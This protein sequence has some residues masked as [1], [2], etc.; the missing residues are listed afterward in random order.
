[1]PIFMYS[2]RTRKGEKIDGMVDAPD[3]R[4]ALAQIER[5]G[6]IPVS[7]VEKNAAAAMASSSGPRRRFSF[8]RRVEKLVSRELLLFTTELSDLL[9]SGMKL[10][11]ALN[12]I[13]G[14]KSGTAADRIVA[15]LRDDIIQ[16]ASLS[17]AMAKHPASFPSLYI[18]MIRAGEA[19]G[20]LDEVLGRL[21]LHY[22]KV[23]ETKEKVVM[24]LIYPSIVMVMGLGTLIFSM[25]YIV[26]KF[27]VV[28]K[29]MGQ[30]L[31]LPTRMLIGMSEALV[32]YG[33][34]MAIGL[35]IAVIMANR[36]LKTE[37][38]RLWWDRMLLRLPLVRGIVAASIYA[39]FSRT[40]G[41][42]LGNGVPVLQALA[43]VEKTAGNSVISAEIRKARERVTDGHSIS[44][45][46]AAGK[47]LPA[48]M[49]D[50]LAVGEQ[51]GDMKGALTHI[52]RRYENDL[53]RSVKIF[54]TA[55][56]PILIVLVAVMVGFVAISILLAVFNVT[57]G[58]NI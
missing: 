48:T 6:H 8:Q 16:G 5:M 7:V 36:A 33:W 51:T 1:M 53:D 34:A 4:A 18:S 52:A 17:E 42:L 31:P 10:G 29:Q 57:N 45:P 23:Q 22:E 19:S 32:K 21:V 41:T 27:K 9:A 49:I 37:R 26:P 50:M 25:V 55:L 46:L 2:G 28:F 54:T 58:L 3:R 40:L 13:A 24:A 30:T 20:A 38:G 56:E 35:A 43:I 47:V 11:H 39:N 12:S 44:G 15:A 14:R